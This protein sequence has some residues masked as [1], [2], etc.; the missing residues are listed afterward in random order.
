MSFVRLRAVSALLILTAA[1]CADATRPVTE[2]PV[3]YTEMA[4]EAGFDGY[5]VKPVD[6]AQLKATIDSLL[7]RD[8]PRPEP[9]RR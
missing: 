5:L 8:V 4:R 9:A 7:A 1:A 3:A 6:L 2:Q